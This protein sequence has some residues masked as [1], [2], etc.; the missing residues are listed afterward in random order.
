MPPRVRQ[1]EF[2]RLGCNGH[3][4]PAVRNKFGTAFGGE[5]SRLCYIVTVVEYRKL[6]GPPI[7]NVHQSPGSEIMH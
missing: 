4:T 5:G 6:M 1:L 7:V 2:I 3:C